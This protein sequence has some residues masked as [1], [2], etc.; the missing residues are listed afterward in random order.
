VTRIPVPRFLERV[1]DAL[2]VACGWWLVL[3]S[4]ATCF[5]MVAR[6]L[7]HFSL[8]GVDEVGGY[9]LAV[10]SAIGFAYTLLTRGHTRIDFLVQK[11]P[12]GARA[13]LNALAMASLAAMA[14]FAVWR[15]WLVLGE[16]IEF[17]STATTPLQ[18]PLWIPQALWLAGWVLFALVAT[19]GAA[20]ALSLLLRDPATLNRVY[21]PQTLAEEIESEA[22]DLIRD[23][24]GATSPP[25]GPR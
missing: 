5:E 22:G 8:Q 4:F 2:V 18:T 6:K 15:G 13:A 20:H 21:G 10:A 24:G 1:I 9:T 16:S 7:F 17:Q 23:A 12:A 11:L 14:L 19:I 3:L 25:G